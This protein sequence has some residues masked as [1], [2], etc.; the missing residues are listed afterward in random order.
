M[1][2]AERRDKIIARLEKKFNSAPKKKPDI[3]FHSSRIYTSQTE[4][5]SL[6]SDIQDLNNIQKRARLMRST[7]NIYDQIGMPDEYFWEGYMSRQFAEP[8]SP[9]WILRTYEKYGPY[10]DF[11][12]MQQLFP[13]LI[14]R[15]SAVNRMP[16]YRDHDEIELMTELRP[17]GIPFLDVFDECIRVRSDLID[18]A[19][20]QQDWLKQKQEPPVVTA[21]EIKDPEILLSADVNILDDE[22]SVEPTSQQAAYRLFITQVPYSIATED[23]TEIDLSDPKTVV[24]AIESATRGDR[25][26][27]P[28]SILRAVEFYVGLTD[29]QRAVLAKNKFE[30]EDRKKWLKMKRG[31][32]RLRLTKQG[33]EVTLFIAGRDVA[34]RNQ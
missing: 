14:Q 6:A 17:S 33:D 21:T 10:M 9:G 16:T 26:I 13:A 12:K 27:K 31:K 7:Y 22:C 11:G 15:I 30:P 28:G 29:V 19:V 2:R 34:Y 5:N 3:T 1:S 8:V 23:R 4:I 20:M 18:L 25:S 32:D 24:S